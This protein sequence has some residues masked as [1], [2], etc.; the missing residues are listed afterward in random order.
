MVL[1][2]ELSITVKLH[3]GERFEKICCYEWLESI[4]K[5]LLLMQ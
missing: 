1:D 4:I 5:L 2:V 3:A